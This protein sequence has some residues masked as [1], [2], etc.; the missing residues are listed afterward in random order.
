MVSGSYYMSQSLCML[1]ILLSH[2]PTS[3]HLYD[4]VE[5]ALGFEIG[6]NKDL[7]DEPDACWKEIYAF[8]YTH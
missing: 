4:I 8:E 6:W 7:E 2:R 5:E 1:I 3:G